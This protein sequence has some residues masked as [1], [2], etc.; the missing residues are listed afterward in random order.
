M[1]DLWDSSKG[2]S[3]FY[4]I[5]GL[6]LPLGRL[7]RDE[8]IEHVQNGLTQLSLQPNKEMEQLVLDASDGHPYLVNFTA[9]FC[10]DLLQEGRRIDPGLLEVEFR[11]PDGPL[12]SLIREIRGHL[13]MRELRPVGYS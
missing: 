12:V 2:A 8:I 9:A 10:Y 11:R 7:T 6:T 1:L 13:F 3:P 4:N 5:F